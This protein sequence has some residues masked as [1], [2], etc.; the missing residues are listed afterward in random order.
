MSYSHAA[1]GLLVAA[2]QDHLQRF[3]KP[4]YRRRSLRVFR[5]K[6]GLAVT[7]DLW[8][9][10]RAALAASEYFIL[11]ASEQAA[12]SQWIAQE[13]DFWLSERAPERILLA[14]TDGELHWDAAAADFDW[15]RTTAL[16][17]QLRGAFRSEPLHLDLRWER[18]A[19]D[20]SLRKPEFLDA[21]AR[22][23]SVLRRQPLDD[24]IGED[25]RQH[26]RAR[27]SA[28]AAVGVLAVMLI[29]AIVAALA[30]I[31]QRNLARAERALAEESRAQSRERLL[32]LTVANGLRRVDER[33]LAGA[34][35]W[36]AES[37]RIAPSADP[38]SPEHVRLAVTLHEHP[39]LEQAWSVRGT[40]AGRR[41]VL[42]RDGRYATVRDEH[43][44]R[45]Y[46]VA[47]AVEVPLKLRSTAHRVLDID[48]DEL[49]LLVADGD[50]AAILWSVRSGTEVLRFEYPGGVVGGE[51]SP[52]GRLI[53]LA[54]GDDTVRI[55]DRQTGR[56]MRTLVHTGTLAFY[57]F[58][59]TSR[60]IFAVTDERIAHIWAIEPKTHV[61]LP[62]KERILT[63]QI[64][65]TAGAH[66]SST[67]EA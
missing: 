21:V 60:N 16:P 4:W 55:W 39:M 19:D 1:D 8:R 13:V 52:D 42:S 38:R 36:F 17:P 50:G 29:A 20:L 34:G 43:G 62:H 7:P 59:G 10:I 67:R 12:R 61:A 44:L 28:A 51:F 23:S 64:T 6:T 18:T 54:G 5:D 31:Q 53:L 14:W 32:R 56:L 49:Q 27:R 66:L 22:F 63:I 41:I 37:A 11:F 35:L 25:V 57:G 65:Q 47:S 48:A 15:L 30:A 58:G 40:S 26:R 45:M 9:S 2:L 3:A 46:E 24:L 33:D